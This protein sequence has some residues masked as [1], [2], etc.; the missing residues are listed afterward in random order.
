MFRRLL[1]PLL[2][3]LAGG[4]LALAGGCASKPR[5]GS[6]PATAP[7][8]RR[9]AATVTE[10]LPLVMLGID[11]LEAD[12]FTALSGK[13][14]GLLTHPAGVNRR[15][16]STIDVLR[17]APNVRLVALFAPE[18]GLDGNGK[19]GDN[20]PDTIDPRTGLP[21]YSLHGKTRK[22]TKAMLKGLDALVIDL[23]DIGVRS[24]TFVSAMR[25]TMEACF[26]NGVEVIVL[27]RPNPL[28]G[29]KVDGPPMDPEWLSYVG[30][31]RV[32][33]VH[34]LTIGE[35]ARLA[36]EAPGVLAVSEKI[37][38]RGQLTVV[39]MRGW[40]RAMRWPDTGLRWVATS[41]YVQDYA[42]VV[43]YAM[44]GLGTEL[45]GFTH[46]IG[47]Q[48]PFRGL[49]FKGRTADQIIKELNALRL[50]GLNF[51]KVTVPS[52]DG[53]L[54]TGVYVDVTDYDAW[55]PTALS[56]H[57]M[58]LA[59]KWSTVNPFTIAGTDRQNMFNKLTGSTAW[60]Q[61]LAREGARIDV[62]AFLRNWDERNQVYREQSHKYWLYP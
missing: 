13:K 2:S 45:G 8:I 47:R 59:C 31:F 56:F 16:Q 46:G 62:A 34:G 15:G 24:Y 30:A 12:R 61:A 1:P 33:Y 14:I 9:A 4:A 54:L 7:E 28:G 37:R 43:G 17:R 57:L 29:L 11:V 32:P 26:E 3:G 48:H 20:I 51:V 41:P 18:H 40:R 25:Y 5:H 22:P 49:G 6:L 10:H 60:W 35:L 21:V 50:P 38:T 39:P 52:A 36:K 27:D 23:Q 55:R 53:R 44:T 19:A 42:A 58:R